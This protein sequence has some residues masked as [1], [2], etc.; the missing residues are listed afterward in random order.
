M[1]YIYILTGN[2]P[3]CGA[4]VYAAVE[5]PRQPSDPA[6]FPGLQVPVGSGMPAAYWTCMCHKATREMPSAPEPEVVDEATSVA[7]AD[8]KAMA[9]DAERRRRTP[10]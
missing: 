8:S 9:E 4:P 7:V 3:T 6:E 5:P 2:C 10:T 1:R